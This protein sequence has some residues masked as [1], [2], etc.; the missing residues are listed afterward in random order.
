MRKKNIHGFIRIILD[1]NCYKINISERVL[2]LIIFFLSIH[3]YAVQPKSVVRN[4]DRKLNNVRIVFYVDIHSRMHSGTGEKMFLRSAKALKKAVYDNKRSVFEPLKQ[5][6]NVI[7]DETAFFFC[8]STKDSSLRRSPFSLLDEALPKCDNLQID[9]GE[10]CTF[11]QFKQAILKKSNSLSQNTIVC[12]ITNNPAFEDKI[13]VRFQNN[14]LKIYVLNAKDS[15]KDGK[16]WGK[17]YYTYDEWVEFIRKSIRDNK[18]IDTVIEDYYYLN[19]EEKSQLKKLDCIVGVDDICLKGLLLVPK[20][21][22]W[23]VK[24]YDGSSK[25]VSVTDENA[26]EI[27]ISPREGNNKIKASI[28]S[29]VGIEYSVEWNNI[30]F[31][32]FAND[33]KKVI[34]QV[35]SWADGNIPEL[36]SV[37]SKQLLR[38]KFSDDKRLATLRNLTLDKPVDNRKKDKYVS[39][40]KFL[41]GKIQGQISLLKEKGKLL[42]IVKGLSLSKQDK[43]KLIAEI[44]EALL[45]E[46]NALKAKINEIE[47]KHLLD[48][49][50][51]EVKSLVESK[52]SKIKYPKLLENYDDLDDFIKQINSAKTEKNIIAIG[53]KVENWKEKFINRPPPGSDPINEIRKKKLE[54]LK[55]KQKKHKDYER[56]ITNYSILLSLITAK[57][58]SAS[59]EELSIMQ[60]NPEYTTSNLLEDCETKIRKFDSNIE[61]LDELKELKTKIQNCSSSNISAIHELRDQLNNFIPRYITVTA[62]AKKEL[63][64][65]YDSKIADYPDCINLYELEDYKDE[66][67]KIRI[68]KKEDVQKFNECRDFLKEWVPEEPSSAPTIILGFL[69]TVAGIVIALIVV[70]LFNKPVA[71]VEYTT[72]SSENEPELELRLRKEINLESLGC[73]VDIRVSCIK[74]IDSDKIEF[75]LH[76]PN[77][78]I[79]IGQAGGSRKELSEVYLTRSEGEYLIFDTKTSMREFGRIKLSP[80][81]N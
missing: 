79:W 16:L 73:K 63:L 19:E 41:K 68:G 75:K 36:N 55:Q 34:Q 3:N 50:K 81:E 22:G 60:W 56:D 11:E 51:R 58:N 66:A 62:K 71:I 54:E 4:S 48:S 76:S 46:I 30:I 44:N 27:R 2:I 26:N 12:V 14:R 18:I 38:Q 43:K 9:Q 65:E 1:K 59:A 74:N 20:K 10:V 49:R 8:H 21:R 5:K 23:S 13:G 61:N 33:D 40:A 6:S 47:K 64:E 15:V 53:L 80:I 42:D 31:D 78:N 29:P 70:K 7:I 67:S 57:V 37:E 45:S 69:A 77:Q 24:I 25:E 32:M 39:D 35:I 72:T 17:D 52:R 28:V